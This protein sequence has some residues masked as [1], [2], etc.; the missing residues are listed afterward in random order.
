M[1]D[2]D[3]GLVSNAYVLPHSDAGRIKGCLFDF[4]EKGQLGVCAW[5]GLILSYA[6]FF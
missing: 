4:V 6:F 1:T 3:E 5:S 2:P